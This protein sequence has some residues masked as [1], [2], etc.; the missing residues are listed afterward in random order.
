MIHFIVDSVV[1]DPATY[2]HGL[3]ERCAVAEG[4]KANATPEHIEAQAANALALVG[5]LTVPLVEAARFPPATSEQLAEVEKFKRKARMALAQEVPLAKDEVVE[6]EFYSM[7]NAPFLNLPVNTSAL[8]RKTNQATLYYFF[9]H[10]QVVQADLVLNAKRTPGRERAAMI[11]ATALSEDGWNPA[12]LAKGLGM[13]LVNGALGT[14]GAL[15]FNSIFPP[16]TPSYFGEVYK[17]MTK[18]FKQQLASNEVDKIN[19]RVNGVKLWVQNT[20]TPRKLQPAGRPALHRSD[21]DPDGGFVQEVRDVG[22]P[23]YRVH[24]S[25]PGSGAGVSRSRREGPIE[26]VL[27]HDGKESCVNL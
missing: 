24:A 2:V 6:E 8:R 20:Y 21:R 26:V 17:Q 27:R 25:G 13:G 1:G 9:E 12:D 18:I 23:S 10:V 5:K 11:T 16:G 7:L 14:I 3:I 4:R 19:G 15:I 22:I